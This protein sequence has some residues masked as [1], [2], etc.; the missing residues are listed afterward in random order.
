[1]T[2]NIN[3]DAIEEEVTGEEEAQPGAQETCGEAPSETAEEAQ[4]EKKEEDE[5]LQNK[6]LRL[7]ADFQNFRR[8][9]EKEKHDIYAYANENIVK[10]LLDVID[11]FERATAVETAD[12]KYKEGMMLILKQLQDVL[13]KNNVEEIEALG[14]AFDPN[15]HNA[16]M[17]EAAEAESGTVTKVFQKGYMLNKK[18]IRPAMVVVAQ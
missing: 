17:T 7:N 13:E 11:N 1:M 2:E 16:V 9:A 15:V 12:E 14:Q 8:R 6:F 5:D 18:V 3:K 4:P 10:Q